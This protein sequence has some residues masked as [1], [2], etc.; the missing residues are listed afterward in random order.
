MNLAQIVELLRLLFDQK[1]P[2]QV[3]YICMYV[4]IYVYT[5]MLRPN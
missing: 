1:T 3:I 5:Y 2:C 4:C